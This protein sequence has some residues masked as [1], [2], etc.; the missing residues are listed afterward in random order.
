MKIVR[1]KV[2]LVDRLAVSWIEVVNDD[3]T[4]IYWIHAS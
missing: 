3:F 1:A 4:V 2:D